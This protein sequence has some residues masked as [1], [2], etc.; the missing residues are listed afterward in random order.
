MKFVRVPARNFRLERTTH[1]ASPGN[2]T[3]QNT[4]AVGRFF[5]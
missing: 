4:E 3:P 2:T 1:R 5:F